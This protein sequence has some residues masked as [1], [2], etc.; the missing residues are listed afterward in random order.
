MIPSPFVLSLETRQ[1]RSFT[2][3]VIPFLNNLIFQYTNP[4]PFETEPHTIHTIPIVREHCDS[5]L[6][7]I[8]Y[9]TLEILPSQKPFQVI[10][11]PVKGMHTGTYYRT[12][13]PQNITLSIQDVF[14]TYMQK[15]IEFNENQ[16]TPLYRPSHLENLKQKSEY[17]E[18]PDLETKV[19]TH[20]NPHYW[21]QQDILQT[22]HFQYRFFNNIT[23]TDDTIPQVQIFTQFLLK[24]FRFNYQLLW[25]LQ[26]QP[27]YINFPQILTETE[28]L[29]YIIK[30]ANKH[31]K[32]RD[33]TSL[34]ITFFQQIN[35]DNNC[36]TDYFETSDNR[37]YF[38]SHIP[39]ETTPEEQTLNVIPQ[40]TRQ[41]SIQSEEEQEDLDNPLYPQ[42]TQT[43]DT[44]QIN[45]S[46]TVTLQNTSESSE[47]SEQ[48]V[49]NTQSFTITND[50]NLIQVPIHKI[51]PDQTNDPNQ[52]TT[53][54]LTQDNTS[55]LSTS[56][57][58][59]TQP[60]QVQ[61]SPRQNY[62]PHSIPSQF[63]TQTYTHNSPQQGSSHTQHSTT[64][65]FQTPTPPSPHEIQ[66]STYTPAQTNPIQNVQPGLHI[67]TIHSN[68]PPN[69]I[70]S[71]HLSRPPLQP[72]LTN[73]L[74]YN[75]T[76]TNLRHMQ[77]SSTDNITSNSLNIFPS[78]QM[79]NTIRP[80]LQNSQFQILNPPS[81]TIRTNPHFHNTST[82]S[83][84][85]ISNV[86]TYNT[87]PPSTISQNTL[88]QPTFINSSTSISEPIKPFDGLDHN[89]TSEEYLQHI[90]A[91]VTFSL[92][93]QPTLEQ[94][95][96]FWHARRMAFIQCPLTGTALSWYIRLNDTYKQDWHAF[97]QA[98]KKQFS[99]QKNAYYAQ[100]EALNL[101]KKDTETVRHFALKVQQLVE[102]GWCN[103]N[104]STVNLKCNEIFTK[105][106]PKNLKDFAN[107]RQVKH[108]STVLEP[109]IPFHTLVKLVDAEDIAND[110]IRTPDLALEVNNITKQLQTHTLE[111]TSQEQLM[112]T[113]PKDPNNKNKPAYKKYCSYC[114]RTNHSISACFKKQRDDEDKRA[115]YARSK[116]PQKSFVQ[117]F[118]SPSQDRT[119]NYDNRY[120]SRSTS[121]N[122]SYN[123][124]Y[125][126]N[127]YRSTSRDR[128][129]YDKS[130]TPPQYSRSRYDTYRRDSRSYRSPYRS[131]YR[132]PYR[133]NSRPRYRSQSYSRD[134]NFHKDTNSYRPPS[135]PKD[136]RFFRSRSHSNSRN[137]INTIQTQDPSDPI[138]FEAHMYHPTAM[139]NAVTPTSWF[140]TLYVHTPSSITQRDN[141]SRL[142]IAF[143]LDT[144][145]S[146][147]VLNY[148]TYITLTKLLDI[149]PTHTSDTGPYN[150]SK[151]LTVANQ[152]EVPILHYANIILNTTI[153]ENSRYFS[154]PFAVADIK[155]NILGTPFLK[156]IY[157]TSIYKILLSNSN[158]NHKYTQILQNLQLSYL[159]I[160]H[161]S[162]TFTESTQKPKFA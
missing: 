30:D 59:V 124:T 57:T 143:L 127:R 45:P 25:E 6:Y 46:E 73:P 50:S 119:K 75:L 67:N 142:E 107:K 87:T 130:T 51:N 33:P 53:F 39:P 79:S 131:S 8:R 21:L 16:D 4:L 132:S 98:F 125:S 1:N 52:N 103:E 31:L 102:K 97:V 94:E 41:H 126:Q 63:A 157:R 49:Q 128:F 68:P 9:K 18:V 95:Y 104:A 12:I 61:P 17:F 10:F 56:N 74:S 106:L 118:R 147:S 139:A 117:Y 60:S 32:Y 129:S 54:T 151:T 20:N 13:Y 11:N 55:L 65:H 47:E 115:A 86:P 108:T 64:V 7:Y 36:I 24:F 122:N 29:P 38:T 3:D 80:T 114:H 15:L 136:S 110:K 37:P 93:L 101:S 111:S 42:L 148:P 121:R 34:N 112:F 2:Q 89:Y 152:T 123:K 70:T 146:I 85:N 159:K 138:K 155:Y 5:Y 78:S 137:K 161:I 134:N 120:R 96:K 27:A 35:L 135:R 22:K 113:Q 82:T 90:E 81:T 77:Q 26:D 83:I 145:A 144:G 116:S 40:Y 140:Y 23:L 99:S 19:Q 162:R 28:L 84:T 141:P 160:T 149:R 48:T 62:D 72:I 92:G 91:R 105:G 76:S 14:L 69:S 150:T 44:Q 71:R 153:D 133:H 100:V 154:V 58:N 158:T 109:S 43:P 88:S 156:I 66:T